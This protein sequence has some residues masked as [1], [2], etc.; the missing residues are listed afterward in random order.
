MKVL[1]LILIAV[2]LCID[3]CYSQKANVGVKGGRNIQDLQLD[4]TSLKSNYH[5]G[6]VFKYDASKKTS[7]SLEGLYSTQSRMRHEKQV[8]TET[9]QV[10]LALK[11]F[12]KKPLYVQGGFQGSYLMYI[13]DEVGKLPIDSSDRISYAYLLGVGV[14]IPSGFD[15]SIRYLYPA[16]QNQFN[17]P[18]VQVSL[19]FDIY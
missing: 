1:L 16:N 5:V 8:E 10:P 4:I 6:P 14:G 17:S 11:F 2:G 19:A 15:F 9:I 3:V 18:L 13:R 12:F 7:I